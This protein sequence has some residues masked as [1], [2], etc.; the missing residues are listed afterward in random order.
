MQDMEGVS[1]AA[2]A[3]GVRCWEGDSVSSRRLHAAMCG[4]GGGNSVVRGGVARQA[5]GMLL[6]R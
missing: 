1:A 6:A 3:V 2:R 4:H 5:G